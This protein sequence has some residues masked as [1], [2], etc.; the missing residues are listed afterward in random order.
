M[1]KQQDLQYMW[2]TNF[3]ESLRIFVSI[4]MIQLVVIIYALSFLS[5][6][7]EFLRKLSILTLM[8]QFI[9]LIL[10][11]LLCKL[12]KFFNQLDVIKGI[13]VL[14]LLVVVITTVIAQIIGY[15]DMQLTFHL[16]EN[17]DAIN[18]LNIKL[19]VSTVLICLSLVRYFYVQ[20]QW[21]KQ[22][23]K[24]SEARL[25]ALQARIKP[26]FLFNSLN[27]IASL[28]SFNADQAEIAIADFSHLMRRTFTHK[29]ST[30]SIEEELLWVK[31]YLAIEKLR[32]AER[33]QYDIEVDSELLTTSIPVLCVQPLVENAI[34]HGIQPLEQ[35]GKIDIRILKQNSQLLIEVRNPYST[36]RMTHTSGMALA[37]IKE[38]LQLQYGNK[39]AMQI[40]AGV[41][42]YAVSL[43]IPL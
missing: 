32:L 12:N 25:N 37:N 21:H 17:Q 26:H 18:Y 31:K 42:C 39:A 34:L 29:E 38:R 14:V 11:I 15:L 28:I 22:V 43:S 33:L 19:T 20:D 10:L 7:L 40:N 13:F 8:A 2:L 27:T 35:G 16:F 41:D 24:L 4:V 5:Y 30:I 23:Q 3:C 36:K 9:G 1:P 6:D